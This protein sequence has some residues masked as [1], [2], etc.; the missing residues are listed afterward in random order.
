MTSPDM[1]PSDRVD[2]IRNLAKSSD[3]RI[4]TTERNCFYYVSDKG[5]E[6][7]QG[8][9]LDVTP[10]VNLSFLTRDFLLGKT[11]HRISHETIR[12]AVGNMSMEEVFRGGVSRIPKDELGSSQSAAL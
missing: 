7:L 10:P 8:M 4:A 12:A 11:P 6:V 1:T 2:A 5:K 9:G 3:L